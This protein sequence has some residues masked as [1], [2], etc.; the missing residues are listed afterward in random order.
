[1]TDYNDHGRV[2]DLV[3]RVAEFLD[4]LEP[5]EIVVH[6]PPGAPWILYVF[7][8]VLIPESAE[9]LED[10]ED[11]VGQ[12]LTDADTRVSVWIASEAEWRVLRE[13]H[14]HTARHVYLH[15][16]SFRRPFGGRARGIA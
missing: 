5:V 11:R 3:R 8:F 12:Q 6:T 10:L 7:M 13:R 9:G 4:A 1:M 16:M 15:G 14:A 2:H